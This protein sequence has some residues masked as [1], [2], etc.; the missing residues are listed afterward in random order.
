MRIKQAMYMKDSFKED[1]LREK[2][3]WSISMETN[4]LGCGQ[5]VGNMERV[6]TLIMMVNFM[7]GN[8]W[9]TQLKELENQWL[10]EFTMKDNIT[11]EWNMV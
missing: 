4:I 9:K 6:F 10:T 1:F 2:A 8:G 7:M 5:K 3:L 11:R